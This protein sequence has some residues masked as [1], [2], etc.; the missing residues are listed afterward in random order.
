MAQIF[1]SYA[2]EDLKEAKELYQRLKAAGFNPWMDKVD[3]LPG[4]KW[5][6]AIEKAIKSADFF[7]LCLST[8]SVKKRGFVQ[9]EIRTALDLWQEKLEDDIYLIPALIEPV[10]HSE[11]PDEVRE[12]QWVELYEEDG[13]EQLSNALE[14]EAARRGIPLKPALP[15]ERDEAKEAKP[16]KAQGPFDKKADSPSTRPFAVHG[17]GQT[18]ARRRG[19]ESELPH[20]RDDIRSGNDPDRPGLLESE[21]RGVQRPRQAEAERFREGFLERPQVVEARR[22][23]V[24]R[25]AL[26]QRDFGRRKISRG[27]LAPGRRSRDVLDVEA[28]MHPGRGDDDTADETERVRQVERQRRCGQT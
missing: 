7:I 23:L 16:A 27:D 28:D 19:V 22:P 20:G 2:R 18:V 5:R 1:I 25:G 4:K 12:F 26:D 6:P 14:F 13:W 8:R 24:F 9:R 3:L 21:R 15:A 17:N 11:M 10:E